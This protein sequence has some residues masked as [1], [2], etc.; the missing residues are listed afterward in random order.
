MHEGEAKI[1]D[2]GFAKILDSSSLNYNVG[3]PLYMSPEAAIGKAF[4][5]KSDI[6]SYCCIFYELLYGLP[7]FY[8]DNDLCL[9]SIV[10]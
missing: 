6:W 4:T 10:S 8:S 2:F 5:L 1:A 9:K 7:P 3:T